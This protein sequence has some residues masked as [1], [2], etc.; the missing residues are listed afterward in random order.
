M[1]RGVSHDREEAISTYITGGYHE[2]QSDGMAAGS[3]HR[4]GEA[5]K[6]AL[7]ARWTKRHVAPG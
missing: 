5:E 7:V 6:P 1:P 4:A 3:W 2:I